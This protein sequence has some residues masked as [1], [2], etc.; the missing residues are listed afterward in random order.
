MNK[1]G[2]WF[3]MNPASFL[4]GLFVILAMF[5]IG[6]SGSSNSTV[7]TPARIAMDMKTVI[8]CSFAN[9]N[10][11]VVTVQQCA[12]PTPAPTATPTASPTPS[13][14]PLIA[15]FVSELAPGGFNAC[16]PPGQFYIA[17]YGCIPVTTTGATVTGTL[18]L[19]NFFKVT[20]GS[21]SGG[22]NVTATAVTFYGATP[23][24][25]WTYPTPVPV[26]TPSPVV[27]SSPT[28]MPSPTGSPALMGFVSETTTYGFNACPP[29][30]QTYISG[31]GC[32]PITTTSAT[33]F[34]TY[35]VGQF[36]KVYGTTVAP[37]ITATLI[38]Y[39]ATSFGGPTPTPTTTPSPTPTP[40]PT[41]TPTVAP[42]AAPSVL[43]VQSFATSLPVTAP[44]A[45]ITVTLGTAGT[46]AIAPT[47]GDTLLAIVQGWGN[48]SGCSFTT[49]TGFTALTGGHVDD[50]SVGGDS[51]IYAFYMGS[52]TKP[53]SVTFA[54]GQSLETMVTIVE[55]RNAALLEAIAAGGVTSSQ[56]SGYLANT[57]SGSAARLQAFPVI[58]G[59]LDDCC[60]TPSL[61]TGY[62]QLNSKQLSGD[63]G[64]HSYGG[65]GA[66]AYSTTLT[67]G[68][69]IASSPIS[70]SDG[71]T[72]ILSGLKI[73]VEP[74]TGST[75]ATPSPSPS[76]SST[77]TAMP[78][79]TAAPSGSI[80]KINKIFFGP[81]N[82]NSYDVG[83]GQYDCSDP[84]WTG[85]GSNFHPGTDF[86]ALEGWIFGVADECENFTAW[87]ATAPSVLA[88]RYTDPGRICVTEGFCSELPD[89]GS[90]STSGW[91]QGP[92]GTPWQSSYN[93]NTNTLFT[94][95]G[96]SIALNA[97]IN[98][99]NSLLASDGSPSEDWFWTD[100]DM[101][102]SGEYFDHLVTGFNPGYGM[103]NLQFGDGTYYTDAEWM[104]RKIRFDSA[105]PKPIFGEG[106]CTSGNGTYPSGDGSIRDPAPADYYYTHSPKIIA[107]MCE[108]FAQGTS[109]N[110]R[111][112]GKAADGI[113]GNYEWSQAL[114]WE[115]ESTTISDA[116]THKLYFIPYTYITGDALGGFDLRGYALASE[117]LAWDPTYSVVGFQG[118][119]PQASYVPAQPE[120]ML[121]PRDP[122]VSLNW[123]SRILDIQR[124]GVYVREYQNCYFAGNN[125]GNCAFIVQ[126]EVNNDGS[127]ITRTIPTLAGTY[128]YSMNL[129]GTN[130]IF[131]GRYGTTNLGDGN[132]SGGPNYD[133]ITFVTKPT[134]ITSP[135]WVILIQ[136]LPP[137]S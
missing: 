45:S 33:S 84:L 85:S 4:A 75:S 58:A 125:V 66:V 25:G 21:I 63:G 129:S 105:L 109:D 44:S 135:G 133:G 9:L 106:M 101:L 128:N 96:S 26:V 51:C 131:T 116:G 113:N 87:H 119:W 136:T 99:M 3:F 37:N 126:P 48:F 123:P 57:G 72:L 27:T 12:T 24:P 117:M 73:M 64:T 11:S 83:G 42:T 13:A 1:D 124:S 130:G 108:N 39:S 91:L 97:T 92:F 90:I 71:G 81:W 20:A 103:T 15:G 8:A 132:G 104:T 76:P 120:E 23:P 22:S 79:P 43:Y 100:D 69:T 74:D 36:F 30:G 19:G 62:T 78:S 60:V 14:T 38:Y 95:P 127:A 80:P 88:V 94:D 46:A 59:N 118:G 16:P 18:A 110:V 2:K 49:P 93:S 35:G 82:G 5:V 86:S 47:T 56:T 17:P 107:T 50:S 114:N 29:S 10:A 31:Y 34:G 54:S 40:S 52:G 41:A 98:M 32:I 65:Q 112:S 111:V 7:T 121:V 68:A 55:V 53:S 89:V 77:P 70:F 122:R 28:P 115:I 137:T 134:T 102:P 6:C 61:P 67:T